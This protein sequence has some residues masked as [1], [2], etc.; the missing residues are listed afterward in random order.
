MC[1]IG[2]APRYYELRKSGALFSNMGNINY[3]QVVTTVLDLSII[4]MSQDRYYVE[5][6]I[7]LHNIL[8]FQ[9]V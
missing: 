7:L 2:K 8:I 6:S 9:K 1:C 3:G 4:L 5:C